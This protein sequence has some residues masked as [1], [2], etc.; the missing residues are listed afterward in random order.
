[1]LDHCRLHTQKHTHKVVTNIH[2]GFI[3]NPTN[4]VPGR[5]PVCNDANGVSELKSGLMYSTIGTGTASQATTK[6]IRLRHCMQPMIVVLIS[7]LIIFHGA[8]KL[9]IICNDIHWSIM[10]HVSENLTK[11]SYFTPSTNNHRHTVCSLS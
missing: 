2:T 7:C 8:D 3:H 11:S 4:A 6:K 9:W 10:I 5:L 1:M